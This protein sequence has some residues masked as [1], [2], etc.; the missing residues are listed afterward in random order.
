MRRYEIINDA[1]DVLRTAEAE[2]TFRPTLL[3]GESFRLTHVDGE[4]PTAGE[5]LLLTV[6]EREQMPEL[7]VVVGDE[8]SEHG[9]A[10]AE[11]VSKHRE[12]PIPD[13]HQL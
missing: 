5:S 11:P 3:A 8:P 12:P 6:E 9:E 7:G 1:G 4:P 10:A 2:D 13:D